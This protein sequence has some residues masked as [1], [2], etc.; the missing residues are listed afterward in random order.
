LSEFI[1][2]H[3]LRKVARKHGFLRRLLWRLDFILIWSL[4]K[5]FQLLPVDTASRL[6]QRV[7]SFIGPRMTRKHAIYR[8]N[9]AQAFP[10]LDDKALDELLH[11]AWG[12]AGRVLAE[13]PHLATIL[14]DDARLQIDIR[15]HIETYSNPDKPCVIVTAHQSNWEIVCTAMAKLGMPN[16]SLYT[17]P[18]NPLLDKL[19]ADHREALNCTLLPRDNSARPLM[20]ALRGGRTAGLV[21][22]RRIDE[23]EPIPFFGR[24]KLSTTMPAKLA[25]K[26]NCEMVPVQVERVRDANYRVTFH[27]PVKPSN[28]DASENEQVI[29]MISQVHRQFEAWIRAHPEDWFCS[30]RLW[31]KVKMNASHTTGNPTGIDSYAA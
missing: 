8:D 3:S 6:G 30:K 22:D 1:L 15:E 27:P 9:L 21:M 12:R 14:E 29:D 26:F 19:L 4:V 2:G 25:L 13:Y 20:R 18:T 11:T 31:P 28:P 23:G 17:P 7:G 5:L 16:A 24:D 10:D